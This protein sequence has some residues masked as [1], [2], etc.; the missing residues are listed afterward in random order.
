[1]AGRETDATRPE[2]TCRVLGVPFFTGT[3]EESLAIAER[4]GLIV[5]PSGPGMACDLLRDEAYREA[6]STADLALPDS[7][8]MVLAQ[9]LFHGTRMP[10][11][12]GLRFLR[13]LLDD[14]GFQSEPSFWV[15]PSIADQEQNLALLAA[16]GIDVPPERTYLAPRYGPGELVDDALLERIQASSAKWVILCIGGG[17]QERLGLYLRKHLD[18]CPAII[19]TGAAIGF[20]SGAQ[21]SIPPWADRFY[22]GWLLR[23]FSKPSA[24][25]PRYWHSRYL[26]AL[27][28]RWRD[29][30]PPLPR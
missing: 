22:L 13:L 8:L 5:F 20:L 1:M 19:C 29:Q 3:V 23:C 26:P 2:Q 17:V 10:R 11:T 15:M 24:F 6:V 21:T 30:M 12:S 4:G 9:N 14:P 27:I 7:A 28:W 18:P 25:V 16:R